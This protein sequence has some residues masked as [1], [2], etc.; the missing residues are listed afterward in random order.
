MRGS[1]CTRPCKLTTYTHTRPLL[2]CAAC[3]NA[4]QQQPCGAPAAAT[5]FDCRRPPL[6]VEEQ[7]DRLR[8]WVAYHKALLVGRIYLYGNAS[9]LSE[10]WLVFVGGAPWYGLDTL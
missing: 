7:P 10:V 5:I 3:L 9:E 2:P 8:E 4:A 1:K 6:P